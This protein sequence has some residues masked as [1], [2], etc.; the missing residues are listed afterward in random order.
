MRFLFSATQTPFVLNY[1]T[2]SFEGATIAAMS[3]A[4]NNNVGYMLTYVMDAIN[5]P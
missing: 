4:S 1:R 2:D 5:C 3:E